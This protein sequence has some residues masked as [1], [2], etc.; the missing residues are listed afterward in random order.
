MIY[1]YDL[2]NEKINYLYDLTLDKII[3]KNKPC[4]LRVFTY[5]LSSSSKIDKLKEKL[6]NTNIKIEKSF[7]ISIKIILMTNKS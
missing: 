5:E 1:N 4:S 7:C 6:K 2:D 3:A